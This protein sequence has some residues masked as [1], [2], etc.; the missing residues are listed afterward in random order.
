MLKLQNQGYN[1]NL[2]VHHGACSFVGPYLEDIKVYV[3][4]KDQYKIEKSTINIA[5][6]LPFFGYLMM[7]LQVGG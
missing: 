4:E 7:T 2:K 3:H 5:H 1:K 6:F